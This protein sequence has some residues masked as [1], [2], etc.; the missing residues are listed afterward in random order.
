MLIS[1][2]NRCPRCEEALIPGKMFCP[3][4]GQALAPPDQKVAID[5][6]VAAKVEQELR[7]RTKDGDAVIRNVAF[8]A[9]NEAISRLKRYWWIG[10]LIISLAGVILAILGVASIQDAKR[11]IVAEARQRV[12]PVVSDVEKRAK[13]AQANLSDVEKKLP[14]VTKSLNDTSAL[15]DKQRQRIEGQSAEVAGK[16]AAFEAASARANQL[17]TNFETKASDAQKRLD[18]MTRRYDTSLSQISRAVAHTSIAQAYPNLDLP[19]FI[20]IG[21]VRFDTTEKKPSETWVNLYLTGF[22]MSKHV[23]SQ[24]AL[25]SIANELNRDGITVLPGIISFGGPAG[26]LI[27]R[28]GPGSPTESSVIYFRPSFRETAEKITVLCSKYLTL[29]P[30]SPQLVQP[31]DGSAKNPNLDF[32]IKDGKLDAQ[33]FVS[34]PNQ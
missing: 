11:T 3:N 2:D 13:I 27:E 23:V 10:A 32:V 24:Q 15:A 31:S 21:G 33:I 5:A 9:E 18:D 14:G 6:Y 7:L 19:R 34:A 1:A 17:S 25:E 28:A 22:A 16:I 26:G 29:A 8:K 20:A 30:G 12:E 4:C